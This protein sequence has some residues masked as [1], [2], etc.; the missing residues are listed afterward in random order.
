MPLDK[1]L[2]DTDT[3]PVVPELPSAITVVDDS[4]SVRKGLGRLLKAQG[5]DVVTYESA[6]HFLENQS[7]PAQLMILDISLPGMS[8]VQLL[9][10]L[11]ADGN[12]VP[13]IL[14]TALEESETQVALAALDS[15]ICL[16]KPVGWE[17]LSSSISEAWLG[18]LATRA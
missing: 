2:K 8:G 9:T 14:I 17:T 15:P 3:K 6:E 10:K 18:R 11:R 5:F 13:V 7:I 1:E 4:P 16:R 12:N